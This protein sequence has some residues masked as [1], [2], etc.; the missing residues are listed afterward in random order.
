MAALAALAWLLWRLGRVVLFPY[1]PANTAPET[2]GGRAVAVRAPGGGSASDA[3]VELDHD[4]QQRTQ[5][6]KTYRHDCIHTRDN[7][8]RRHKRYMIRDNITVVTGES[9]AESTRGEHTMRHMRRTTAA[10]GLALGLLLGTA[11]LAGAQEVTAGWD[12]E[13]AIFE[14]SSNGVASEADFED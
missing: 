3:G 11:G 13:G 8:I 1:G 7:L 12:G 14:I 9:P 6:L 4:Q 5:S 10:A 2:T